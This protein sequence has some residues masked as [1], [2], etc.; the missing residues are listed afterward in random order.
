[1][2][3]LNS[4]LANIKISVESGDNVNE[5]FN[6]FWGIHDLSIVAIRCNNCIVDTLMR[7]G[8]VLGIVIGISFG[9]I[10]FLLLVVT[11]HSRIKQAN[12]RKTLKK[13]F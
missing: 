9:A 3:P 7:F 5:T 10:A 2:L 12:Y 4:K 13:R 11:V 8:R 6:K 1:M